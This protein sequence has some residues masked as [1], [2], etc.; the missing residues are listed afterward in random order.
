MTLAQMASLTDIDF[1]TFDLDAPIG[2]LTTN[3]QQ[4]TL[5]RFLAQGSTL[6]RDRAQLPLRARG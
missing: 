6:A 1:A 5:K 4:G 2:E 3:G